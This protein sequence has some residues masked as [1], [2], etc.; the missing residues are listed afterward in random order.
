[1][2]GGRIVT[3]WSHKHLPSIQLYTHP[4]QILPS[5]QPHLLHLLLCFTL[6]DQCISHGMAQPAKQ[7]NSFSSRQQPLKAAVVD[8]T[9][10]FGSDDDEFWDNLKPG[11]IRAAEDEALQRQSQWQ[12]TQATQ[13]QPRQPSPNYIDDDDDDEVTEV[14]P[15]APIIQRLPPKPALVAQQPPYRPSSVAGRVLNQPSRYPATGGVALTPSQ[16]NPHYKK[17][18]PLF[19]STNGGWTPSQQYTSNRQVLY[20]PSSQSQTPFRTGSQQ[21]YIPAP[22]GR[23]TTAQAD[24]D[25]VETLRKQLEEVSAFTFFPSS[26]IR[27]ML[28]CPSS[29]DKK[30]K[31]S[32]QNSSPSQAKCP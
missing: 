6:A 13:R 30:K 16:N 9:N 3:T 1:M 21:G 19:N 22:A 26:A 23:P 15:P 10:Y 25:D 4:T 14:P 5:A 31:P 18:V 12:A 29:S 28:T 2:D 8:E 17:P 7:G 20:P 27:A 11:D 24:E 32:T